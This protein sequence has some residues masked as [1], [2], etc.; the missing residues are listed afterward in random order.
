MQEKSLELKDVKITYK[1]QNTD[2]VAAKD[3]NLTLNKGDSLGIIGESGSGKTS[4][5]MA[6]MGLLKKP[7]KV[8][9]EIYYK[10][11]DLQLVNKKELNKIR[12][13]KIAIVFQNC[14]EVLNPVLN[15]HEQIFEC[16]EKHIK[17]SKQ[18]SNKKVMELLKMVGLDEEIGKCYPHQLSGGMRQR[19][20]IAMALSCDPEVL[21][22]DEPTTALDAVSK[23]EIINLIKKMQKLKRFTLIII[24]HEIETI[25]KLTSRVA[26]MYSGYIVEEGLTKEVINNPMNSYTRGLINS[27]PS[28][29][30]YKDM[31]GIAG[32]KNNNINDGCSF[33][34][35]CNQSIEICKTKVPKLE[36][37][38]LNRKVACNRGGIVTLLHGSNI[39]KVYSSNGRRVTACDNCEIKIRHGEVIALVGE[40]G[41]GKSTF[42]EIL[43][44][45][46]SPDFGE[47]IFQ[48]K[49][50]LGNS[51]TCHKHGIQIVFQDPF[52]A[53]NEQFTVEDIVKEPLDILKE[54]DKEERKRKVIEVLKE[55]KL[56]Y[57]ENFLK[58]KCYMLSGGQRQRLALARSLIME[59][60]LLI[61]DEINSMLDPST[62]A[63]IL[64]LLKGFQNERGFAMIYIT[65]DLNIALKIADQ[66][67]VMHKGKIIEKGL[68]SQ[69]FSN[70]VEAYTK[71]LVNEG[72]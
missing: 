60:K 20:L 49:K 42:A 29:N 61:A 34:G 14:L 8:D 64:R 65:H 38:A 44:G 32:E 21:I 28:I 22:A 63:N 4:L 23:N 58:Y 30:I 45:I 71:K 5:A 31:W 66:T 10:D 25:L 1:A 35:R 9:G 46:I 57:D 36:W 6:I 12:W 24:S 53:T 27:S 19:V 11:I 33:Y 67:Y 15:I 55:V 7:T 56:P 54:D 72:I 18:E 41:S 47:I 3:I 70:P 2:F 59:P 16:I 40:S 50:V 13:S 51:A 52:S 68:T 39:N 69:I 43:S 26:V 17:I 37:V 62:Q 48:E